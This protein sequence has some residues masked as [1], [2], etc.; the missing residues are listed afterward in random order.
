MTADKIKTLAEVFISNNL[1]KL[2]ACEGS[3]KIVLERTG[4]TTVYATT[5]VPTSDINGF[6]STPAIQPDGLIEVTSPI[7]GVF[8]SAPS[9]DSAPFVRIGDKVRKG[10][11]LCIIEA[12]KLLNEIAAETDGEIAD[13]CVKNGDIA[14]YGQTL[15]KLVRRDG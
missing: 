13:I 15:F 3:I 11:V 4:A 9:P 10:D 8:Y 14:E 7:V 12:M 1:T 6:T 2:E 5:S